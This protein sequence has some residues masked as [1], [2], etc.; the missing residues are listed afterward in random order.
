ML[1]DLSLNLDRHAIKTGPQE[2]W[3]QGEWECRRP[4][5]HVSDRTMN[6]LLH[7]RLLSRKQM[8]WREQANLGRDIY[9]SEWVRVWGQPKGRLNKNSKMHGK[10]TFDINQVMAAVGL[11]G[12][13]FIDKGCLCL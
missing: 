9:R 12:A 3:T 7:S 1:L 5:C 8:P 6:Q 13:H 11:C 2:T 4:K 10:K